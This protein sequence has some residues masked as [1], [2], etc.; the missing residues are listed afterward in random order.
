MAMSYAVREAIWIRGLF[1]E[2]LGAQRIGK[3]FSLMV[4]ADHQGAIRIAC[5]DVVNQRSKHIEVRY[6]G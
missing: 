5:N 6:H 1:G 2:L 4:G 3:T